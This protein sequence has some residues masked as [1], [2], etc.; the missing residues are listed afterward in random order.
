MVSI[1]K[2][3]ERKKITHLGPKQHIWH[4]LDPF[5]GI[6]VIVVVVVVVRVVVAIFF[7]AMV[8]VVVV[9]VSVVMVEVSGGK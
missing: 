9:K 1:N 6:V 7:D 2:T 3:K 8:V 4:R 5:I